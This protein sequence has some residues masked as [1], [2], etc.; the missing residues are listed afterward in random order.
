MTFKLDNAARLRSGAVTLGDIFEGIFGADAPVRF[1]AYDGS[2]AGRQD[3]ALGLRLTSPRGV[4]YLATAPRIT[5][6]GAGL[7]QG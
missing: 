7:P 4:C 1:S 2:T 5:G 3:A 6:P